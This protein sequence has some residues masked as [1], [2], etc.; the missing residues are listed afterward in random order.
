MAA[1]KSELSTSQINR[2]SINVSPLPSFT[3]VVA[4]SAAYQFLL[5]LSLHLA[6]SRNNFMIEAIEIAHFANAGN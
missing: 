2:K 1:K 6:I 5:R 4:A 3:S